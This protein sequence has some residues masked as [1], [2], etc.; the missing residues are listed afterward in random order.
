MT[1]RCLQ[2]C[3]LAASACPPVPCFRGGPTEGE[4]AARGDKGGAASQATA[5]QKV[6][7]YS[8]S[9]KSKP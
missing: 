9:K 2:T 5:Q 7:A 3:S 1:V 4:R 8:S 6:L